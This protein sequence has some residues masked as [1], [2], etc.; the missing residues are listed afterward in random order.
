MVQTMPIS[1][2]FVSLPFKQKIPVENVKILLE[3]FP[4]LRN[5]ML[6]TSF[7]PW[8]HTHT[9]PNV[10]HLSRLILTVRNDI[11]IFASINNSFFKYSLFKPT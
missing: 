4:A 2:L 10:H 1:I 6:A 9:R 8:L 5:T 7:I 3:S 11:I